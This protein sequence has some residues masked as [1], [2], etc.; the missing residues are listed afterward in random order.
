MA[1]NFVLQFDPNS[2]NLYQTHQI[3]GDK[4]SITIILNQL[5]KALNF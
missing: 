3:L 1:V 2:K 4:R 5:K